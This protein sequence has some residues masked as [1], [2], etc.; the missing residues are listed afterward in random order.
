MSRFL[1]QIVARQMRVTAHLVWQEEGFARG[2][3]EEDLERLIAQ[4][5]DFASPH[6]HTDFVKCWIDGAPLPPHFTEAPLVDGQ[7]DPSRI[8]ISEEDL[9]AA[10]VRYD[11]EGVLL[12]MH[13]AGEGAIRTALNAIEKLRKTDGASM[14]PQEIAH[15]TFIHPDDRPRF[16]QLN[17]IAEFSPAIWH[18]KTPEFAV[19]DTGY[20][21]ATMHGL[22][23]H[24]T[25]G[26]DWIITENPNLFPALQG[27]LERGSESVSLETALEMM[28]LSGA[29]AVGLDHKIGTLAAGKSADF[30]ILDRNLF[31]IP[32]DQVG[33]T[34]VLVT[35]FEGRIVY[36][37][38]EVVSC[39]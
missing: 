7:I 6:V 16:A 18:L 19:L 30:I 21:F 1:I 20:T 14:R 11:R 22:G 17:V 12:K 35:V 2:A 15:C 3:S 8:Q 25:V 31:E 33:D 24:M 9:T 26:S 27:M 5:K 39:V 36:R 34:K 32:T 29:R 10:L 28:T 38:L 13:C 4:R 23:T 37:D